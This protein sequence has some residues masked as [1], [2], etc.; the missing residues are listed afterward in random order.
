MGCQVQLYRCAL[1]S[2]GIP[3]R[4]GGHWHQPTLHLPKCVGVL[5]LEKS[6]PFP[7]PLEKDPKS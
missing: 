7:N 6:V 3:L 5:H 2:K 4:V 1:H